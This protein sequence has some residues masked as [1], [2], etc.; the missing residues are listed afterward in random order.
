MG[1]SPDQTVLSEGQTKRLLETSL[2]ETLDPVGQSDFV[3][4][5]RKFGIEQEDWAKTVK[6]V[7]KA[8]LDNDI[9]PATLRTMGP[10]NADQMLANWTA[11]AAG[12]DPTA[13]LAAAVVTARQEVA[14]YVDAQNAAGAKV[15]KNLQEGLAEL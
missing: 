13:V 11:P 12:G 2:A 15:A 10:R 7:V 1:L 14:A 9:A 8:A 5:T 6:D 4:L 3:Q